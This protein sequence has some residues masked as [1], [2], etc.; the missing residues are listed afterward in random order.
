MPTAQAPNSAESPFIRYA[1]V[2]HGHVR[3]Q[4]GHHHVE[5]VARR[6][7]RAE[8][9]ADEGELGGVADL[10]QARVHRG[11]IDGERKRRHQR[12]DQVLRRAG[13]PASGRARIRHRH[14][15]GVAGWN[16][17]RSSTEALSRPAC[18]SSRR[19]HR[20]AVRPHGHD[21]GAGPTEWEGT[22][23]SDRDSASTS[24]TAP[25]RAGRP[26]APGR[27]SRGDPGGRQRSTPPRSSSTS[28]SRFSS[29][30]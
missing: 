11:E 15:S 25:S 12:G 29:G 26:A 6:V 2:P 7:G 28:S 18:R 19:C 10:G 9:L 21:A 20:R 17:S 22:A 8:H 23:R 13:R 3:E 16:R 30:S 27:S 5:R 1:S 24:S 4:V 14:V